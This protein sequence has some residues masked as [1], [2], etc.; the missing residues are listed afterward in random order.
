M[1]AIQENI[2]KLYD[3]YDHLNSRITCIRSYSNSI[4]PTLLSVIEHNA[5]N[6]AVFDN[7]WDVL[8]VQVSDITLDLTDKVKVL[9]TK[10]D[11]YKSIIDV[12]EDKKTFLLEEQNLLK[13]RQLQLENDI[14]EAHKYTLTI[15]SEGKYGIMERI[16]D[17]RLEDINCTT[18]NTSNWWN[19]INL[20]QPVGRK[21]MGTWLPHMTM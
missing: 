21:S 17:S 14:E 4:M 6:V 1:F 13:I 15:A 19:E 16:V 9:Y 2:R 11:S 10:L 18:H 5:K 12:Y 20:P 8:S 3:D 7:M